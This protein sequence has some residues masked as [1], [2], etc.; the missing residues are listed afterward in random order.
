MMYA[1]ARMS[2]IFLVIRNPRVTACKSTRTRFPFQV[3]PFRCFP[4]RR[5]SLMIKNPSVTPCKTM[6]KFRV[7]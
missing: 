7:P 6:S 1:A 5:I 4:L 3:F 2:V